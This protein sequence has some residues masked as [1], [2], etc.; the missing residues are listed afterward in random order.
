MS[1][2]SYSLLA[3]LLLLPISSSLKA[4]TH[5][6]TAGNTAMASK[7]SQNSQGNFREIRFE[8]KHLE[9]HAGKI[10]DLPSKWD[11]RGNT[12]SSEG[13]LHRLE[14]DGK[15]VNFATQISKQSYNHENQLINENFHLT[16][17]D[18]SGQSNSISKYSYIT[19][20]LD[21]INQS[22]ND[23][24]ITNNINTTYQYSANGL[25]LIHI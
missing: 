14:N 11:S 18:G 15:L 24:G 20:K 5:V 17:T 25:S 16:Y 10:I 19:G 3:C 4:Q 8:A 6:R 7:I 21:S 23:R 1:F 9:P 12:I 2:K 22:I 13:D